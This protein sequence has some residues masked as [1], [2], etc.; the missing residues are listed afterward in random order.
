MQATRVSETIGVPR[1]CNRRAQLQDCLLVQRSQLRMNFRGVVLLHV[2]KA[3][4]N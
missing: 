4:C 2:A 1:Q 3:L